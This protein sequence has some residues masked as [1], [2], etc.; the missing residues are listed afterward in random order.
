[1][2]VLAWNVQPQLPCQDRHSLILINTQSVKPISHQL[3][4]QLIA[5]I[6][7]SLEDAFFDFAEK[8]VL[9]IDEY[10]RLLYRAVFKN[11]YGP[12]YLAAEEAKSTVKLGRLSR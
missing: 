10:R 8:H 11:G 9:T 6:M 1:M 5:A 3:A 7:Y 12:P 2:N 4:R